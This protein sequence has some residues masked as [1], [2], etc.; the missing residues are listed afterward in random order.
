MSAITF[1]S[2]LFIFALFF[3][4]GLKAIK[5]RECRVR[6]S[7]FSSKEYW[8]IGEKAVSFGK[9]QVSGA[10]LMAIGL[11]VL[12][13]SPLLGQV[14]AMCSWATLWLV[15]IFTMFMGHVRSHED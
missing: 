7:L 1:I 15:G 13:A 11:V 14:L 8:L 9:S 12:A 4:S 10:S 3:A 5:T 6:P 2:C